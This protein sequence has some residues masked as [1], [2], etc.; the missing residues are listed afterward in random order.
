VILL[1]KKYLRIWRANAWS[2]GLMRKAR[3]R[4]RIFA[5]SIQDSA[6][7]TSDRQSIVV[8]SFRSSVIGHRSPPVRQTSTASTMPPPSTP[9]Q[10]WQSLPTDLDHNQ[11]QSES[12]K[13]TKR[14]RD[15]SIKD[16]D[17]RTPKTT[18]ISHRRSQTVGDSIMSA[19]PH[20]LSHNPYKPRIDISTVPQG[21]MLH[22]ILRKQARRL[23]PTAKSD[24]THTDYFRLK[25]LGIDPDTPVVPLSKKRTRAESMT[26]GDSRIIETVAHE[27]QPGG[28]SETQRTSSDLANPSTIP[29][30]AKNDEDEALFAQIRS[31]R[32]ALAESEQWMQS[33]RQSM[34]RST[35]SKQVSM[36][37]P[38]SETPA[39]RRLREIKERGHQP[40]RTEVRLRAMG[41]KALLP[42][43]FWDGEGMGLSLMKGK[44]KEE[45]DGMGAPAAPLNQFGQQMPNGVMRQPPN[46]LMGFAAL[47]QMNGVIPS[48]QGFH[49]P[50]SEGADKGAS[51]DEA[52]LL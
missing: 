38:K 3:E 46:G 2:M 15:V 31:V 1:S 44:G 14:K 30:T 39:Q 45:E 48:H 32:E 43:G 26:S 16:D 18:R 19:P 10:N 23:A 21:S 9:S 17:Y 11:V 13:A 8:D 22:D 29:H 37:P 6:R 5:K 33:E 27:T 41:D 7:S 34:E 40:S 50:D 42:K 12:G 4:R 36:S 25:A 24:T 20:G 28:Q 51:A 35:A 49:R 47:G 52:I